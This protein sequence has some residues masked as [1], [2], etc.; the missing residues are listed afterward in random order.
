MNCAV[1]L[2]QQRKAI[3]NAKN[4]TIKFMIVAFALYLGDKRGWKPT[5]IKE[6]IEW[7]IKYSDMIGGEY[8]TYEECVTTLREQYGIIV[9][10]NGYMHF[11]EDAMLPEYKQT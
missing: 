5:R 4:Q 6:A 10:E 8:T 2:N 3:E 11:D 1:K 9:K 7:I